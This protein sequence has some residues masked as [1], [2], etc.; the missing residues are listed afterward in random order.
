[1]LQQSITERHKYFLFYERQRNNNINE[2]K[3]MYIINANIF[4]IVY[5]YSPKI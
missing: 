2:Q 1:M 3:K 5:P 4:I